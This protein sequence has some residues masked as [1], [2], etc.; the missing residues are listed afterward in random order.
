MVQTKFGIP[1]V[2]GRQMEV[3]STAVLLATLS[4]PKLPRKTEWRALMDQ[5]STMS[6]E[7][8][9]SVRCP[10]IPQHSISVHGECWH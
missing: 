4:P 1:A 2:A 5:L 6:C 7:A 9:R 8:Y 3:L 10:L